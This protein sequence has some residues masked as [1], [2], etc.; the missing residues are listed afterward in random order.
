MSVSPSRAGFSLTAEDAIAGLDAARERTL[1]IV[2]DIDDADLEQVHSPLMSPL[3]WDLG[4][5]AAYEDL[6]LVHRHGGL[7]LLQPELASCYDAFETPRARRGQVEWLRPAGAHAYLDEV[8]ARAIDV[9]DEQGIGDGLLHEMVIQHERQHCETMLQTLGLARLDYHRPAAAPAPRGPAGPERLTGLE[10]VDVPGGPFEL[11]APAERFSYDNER[12][13]HPVHLAGFELGRTPVTNGAWLDW[14][15]HGGYDRREWWS[16]AG[17]ETRQREGL[18]HP[19]GW[20]AAPDE[21]LGF[22]EW[23]TGGAVALAAE[24]PV[25]HVSCFEA[26]AFARSHGVRLPTELEWERASTFDPGSETKLA[27]PWDAVAGSDETDVRRLRITGSRGS[28][29]SANFVDQELWGTAPVGAFPAGAAPCGALGMLGDVWEWTDSDFNGYP[30]FQAHPYR[31][32]SE[33]FFGDRYKV[34]RGGSWAS[35]ERVATPTFRNWDLPQRRQIFAG[36]RL[37]RDS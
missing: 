27:W 37:A 20:V 12:P 4:H 1:A 15:R 26:Q 5:I 22:R 36:V 2:A 14:I 9:I 3:A 18:E 32:Y 21:E 13:A 17:W 19:G 29:P 24:L 34:L 6:W 30:G 16:S 10:F 23:R 33:V 11:G 31:E 7:P 8:R 35:A 28:G 25:V